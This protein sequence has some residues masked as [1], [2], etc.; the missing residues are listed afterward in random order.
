[1]QGNFREH[2]S[3]A[4][5]SWEGHLM[6]SCTFFTQKWKHGKWSIYV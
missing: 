2:F 3:G 6:S 1:M 5:T 4:K